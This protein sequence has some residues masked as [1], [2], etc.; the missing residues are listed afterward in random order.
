MPLRRARHQFVRDWADYLIVRPA[1]PGPVTSGPATTPPRRLVA[2]VSILVVAAAVI[3]ASLAIVNRDNSSVT[4]EKIG[5]GPA[6]PAFVAVC[7]DWQPMAVKVKSGW[8]I[9]P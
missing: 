1:E 5:H 7:S 4:I 8:L 2:V 3:L 6:L 9:A